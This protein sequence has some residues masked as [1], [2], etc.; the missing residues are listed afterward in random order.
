MGWFSDLFKKEPKTTKFA[1]ML[2]GYMPIYAQ[3]ET[4]IYCS[5]VV[6]QAIKCIADEVKKLNPMHVR[7][8][9]SDPNPVKGNVQNVLDNPNPLM[10]TA[11]FLEKI[12]YLL[13]YNLNVFI[14]P[15]YYTWIDKE[16]GA[17]RR[18]YEAL[19]PI[20]PIQVDFI[21]DASN[22]L[23]V[24]FYFR[25]GETTTIKY[26]DVIHWRTNYALSEYMGGDITGQPDN[27]PL[28]ETLNLN[29]QMLHGIAKAMNASY[30]VNGIVKYNTMLDDGKTEAALKELEGKLSRSESGFLPLDIKADFTP[31]TRNTQI[32]DTDVVKFIDEKI[33]RNFGVPLAILRGDFTKAQYNAFYQH[34]IE[35][36]IISLS[37]A[38]TKKIFTQRE[39]S[40]GNKIELYPKELIFMTVEQ[41]LEMVKLLSNTGAMFENEKRTALGLRPLPELEG[42]RFMSLNWIDA[43]NADLYQIGQN[44]NVNVDIVDKETE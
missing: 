29:K 14:I 1:P 31:I 20:Q 7:Y 19:Y 41:T 17:E 5:D 10:T 36:K 30:E 8:V 4:S 40:F 27:A 38:L 28:L 18:Y 23:F 39:R 21:E 13:M 2:N 26:D 35:E 3:G 6:R 34:T 42:K 33:L 16:T 9:G 15:T 24:K 43:N 37:Q 22:R 44:A 12:T 25:N 32:V 11:E